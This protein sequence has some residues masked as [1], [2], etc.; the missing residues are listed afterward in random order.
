MFRTEA[1]LHPM[2][3]I[4]RLGTECFWELAPQGIPNHCLQ[5]AQ[6]TPSPAR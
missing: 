2:G 1:N 3:G 4:G 6:G 5:T